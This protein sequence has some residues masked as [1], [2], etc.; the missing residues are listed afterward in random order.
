[1]PKQEK[2]VVSSSSS[3]IYIRVAE[4]TLK[5]SMEKRVR[6][7]PTIMRE[8]HKNAMSHSFSLN[9]KPCVV[10]K[11]GYYTWQEGLLMCHTA[12]L[13]FSTMSE[14][15]PTTGNE[16]P[17]IKK[18]RRRRRPSLPV[19]VCKYMKCK[20]AVMPVVLVKCVLPFCLFCSSRV[21]F[22]CCCCS[23]FHSHHGP[24]QNPTNAWCPPV[25]VLV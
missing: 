24:N 18:A 15:N 12:L 25:H 21:L 1:M 13:C 23:L 17:E 16:P 8:M 4:G 9:S 20:S 14:E 11:Q 7:F 5:H 2:E 3:E 6:V 19:S 10:T 22:A